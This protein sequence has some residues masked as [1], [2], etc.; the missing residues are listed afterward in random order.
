MQTTQELGSLVA[1]RR[2]ELK[3]K[4]TELAR[5]AGLTPES[6]SR[7]ERGHLSEFG[8]RKLMALLAALGLE[9]QVV[10]SGATGN[11]DELRKE[12]SGA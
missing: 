4:Q 10:E 3:L 1:S 11:L 5:R 2:K 7:L 12:H 6:L 8:V 9:L